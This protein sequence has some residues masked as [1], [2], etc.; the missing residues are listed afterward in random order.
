MS[1]ILDTA[2]SIAIIVGVRFADGQEA[3]VL[4]ALCLIIWELVCIKQEVA[5]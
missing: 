1:E 4:T 2:V 5:R 3:A